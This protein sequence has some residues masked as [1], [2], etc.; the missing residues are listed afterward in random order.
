[1][2]G[3]IRVRETA[4]FI[5]RTKLHSVVQDHSILQLHLEFVQE[6]KG[7]TGECPELGVASGFA[8][9]IEQAREELTGMTLLYLEE[10]ER[11]GQLDDT[12]AGKLIMVYPLLGARPERER[13]VV[14]CEGAL[15]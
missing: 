14:L 9:S 10:N 5:R 11:L 1:M 15:T 4:L 6:G 7:W 13:M 12:L 3:T 8:D 2:N